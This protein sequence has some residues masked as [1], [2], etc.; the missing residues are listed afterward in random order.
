MENSEI[1]IALLGAIASVITSVVAGYYALRVAQIEQKRLKRKESADNKNSVDA[2]PKPLFSI[3]TFILFLISIPVVSILAF[4]GNWLSGT[5][6]NLLIPDTLDSAIFC[7]VFFII[8]YAISK[9]LFTQKTE[10]RRI[11]IPSIAIGVL[12]MP[13]IYLLGLTLSLTL[14]RELVGFTF[15]INET[16]R[17]LNFNYNMGV[18]LDA[19]FIGGIGVVAGFLLGASKKEFVLSLK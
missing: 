17:I 6:S 18:S 15:I 7:P 14:S 19:M 5:P 9:R 8:S 13:L 11:L 1:I 4:V 16:E 10:I 2:N 12:I 3:G